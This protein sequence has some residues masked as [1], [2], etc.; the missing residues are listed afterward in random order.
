MG[1]FKDS[2]KITAFRFT[3]GLWIEDNE[4]VYTEYNKVNQ[5][6]TVID[7]PSVHCYP[8]VEMICGTNQHDK[9]LNLFETVE[10]RDEDGDVD[11]CMGDFEIINH[12]LENQNEFIVIKYCSSILDDDVFENAAALGYD[13]C[14]EVD[15]NEE[16]D[17]VS[18]NVIILCF[19]RRF[20]NGIHPSIRFDEKTNK[21]IIFTEYTE[22]ANEPLI[23]K[24]SL[25]LEMT[26]TR[27]KEEDEDE[28]YYEDPALEDEEE[29]GEDPLVKDEEEEIGEKKKEEEKEEESFKRIYDQIKKYRE[30]EKDRYKYDPYKDPFDWGKEYPV[31]SSNNYTSAKTTKTTTS[32]SNTSKT[33]YK[34]NGEEVDKKKYDDF[35]EKYFK[36]LE[37]DLF[38][39]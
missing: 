14:E 7:L 20:S 18:E 36:N 28:D 6:L 3:N 9:I 15:I 35:Y 29:C 2:N 19:E 5:C 31:Y 30:E 12:N 22:E 34:V 11:Y 33:V 23:G 1:T 39:F 32:P 21:L 27:D 38:N 13:T 16:A 4:M 8:H 37:K 10:N 17:F 25:P 24:K 26:I